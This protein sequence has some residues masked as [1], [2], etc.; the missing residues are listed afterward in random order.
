M[1][2]GDDDDVQ[3]LLADI[4][5]DVERP[6]LV[7][8]DSSCNARDLQGSSSGAGPSSQ[9]IVQSGGISSRHMEAIIELQ[10]S[11]FKLM[12]FMSKQQSGGEE[13]QKRKNRDEMCYEPKGPILL[14]EDTY[15]LED[16]GHQKLDLR[17]RQK[18]RPVNAD[19]KDYWVK[20]AFDRCDGPILGASLHLEHLMPNFVNESTICK[21]YDRWAYVKIKNYLTKNAG[22]AIET[23]KKLK[24]N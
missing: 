12:E 3:E 9:Q 1:I 2:G 6:N 21:T 5:N 20:G 7:M 18:L 19:P 16:D 15:K 11:S 13:G 23:Q 10:A 8:S 17:L 14:K 22:V 24:V 4:R